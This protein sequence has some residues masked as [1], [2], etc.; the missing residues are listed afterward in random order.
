MAT[1]DDMADGLDALLEAQDADDA[2]GT[3]GVPV[4]LNSYRDEARGG[5][6]GHI[7][8]EMVAALRDNKEALSRRSR[9][10]GALEQNTGNMEQTAA[11]NV[12]LTRELSAAA[13]AQ[14]SS[15]FCGL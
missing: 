2:P 12:R 1:I 14:P 4:A 10:L 5:G 9:H 8:T 3:P 13:A 6:G 15:C 7:D 11:E